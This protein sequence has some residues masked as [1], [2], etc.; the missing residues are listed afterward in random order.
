MSWKDALERSARHTTTAPLM[1]VGLLI[2]SL[3]RQSHLKVKSSTGDM[4]E[5]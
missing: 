4:L 1:S 2:I 5:C 3:R